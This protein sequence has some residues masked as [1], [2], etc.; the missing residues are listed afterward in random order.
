[1][2]VQQADDLSALR[3]VTVPDTGPPF[4]GDPLADAAAVAAATAFGWDRCPVQLEAGAAT[5]ARTKHTAGLARPQP[6]GEWPGQFARLLAEALAGARP[7]RQVLPWTSERARVHL[8]GLAPLFSCGQ[9][10][11]VLRVMMTRPA[12]EVIEMT[13]IV[14]VGTRTRALAVRLEQTAPRLSGPPGYPVPGRTGV[15]G[16]TGPTT[17]PV[18]WVCTD[19]AAA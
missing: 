13:V 6:P 5:S 12:H 1:M 11:R 9:R 10:P 19:V 18:R 3:L 17:D 8:R 14:G 7:M 16:S 15:P 4:D 2:S